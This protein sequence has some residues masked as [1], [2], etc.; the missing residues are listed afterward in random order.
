MKNRL[1]EYLRK[2]AL[3]PLI[4]PTVL[5]VMF[6]CSFGGLLIKTTDMTEG[7]YEVLIT[8]VTSGVSGKNTCYGSIEDIGKVRVICDEQLNPGDRLIVYAS[9]FEAPKPSNPGEYDYQDYLFRKGIRY[10]LMVQDIRERSES[11]A[12][13]KIHHFRYFVR[14]LIADKLRNDMSEDDLAI[15]CALCLGDTS[16]IGDDIRR[17]F[18]LSGCSHLLAVSG[19]HFSSFILIISYAVKDMPYRRK[20]LIQALFVIVIGFLTGWTESVTRAAVMSM[21]LLSGKDRLSG[22]S[23]SAL[24]MML[25]D[26]FCC[27]TLSFQMSFGAGLGMY[28]VSEPIKGKTGSSVISCSLASRAVMLPYFLMNG[29]PLGFGSF[30]VMALSVLTVQMVCLFFLPGFLLSFISPYM[31]YPTIL[32]SRITIIL[33][34]IGED[35]YFDS[36][37]LRGSKLTCILLVFC[38][39][40]VYICRKRKLVVSVLSGTMIV[41]LLTMTPIFDFDK[42]VLFLD[43]GQGDSCL[44]IS[45]N[46]TLLI[47]GG[48]Y[49]EG[50]SVLPSVLDYYQIQSIDLAIATHLDEDH[51]GGIRYLE[52][53]GRVDKIVTSYSDIYETIKEGDVIKAGKV[54]FQ[55]LWPGGRTYNGGNP[56]SVVGVLKIDG[57]KIMMTGDIDEDSERIMVNRGLISDCDI[58]KVA[59]HGSKTSSSLEFLSSVSPEAAVVS[60]A[61]YN[62]YGHP[63]PETLERLG[64]VEANV[65]LTSKNGAIIVKIQKDKYKINCF[66][67]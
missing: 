9:L 47:D 35:Y 7:E 11:K 8:G 37:L 36:L 43:V 66:K 13:T 50:K 15:V 38:L 16:M 45:G 53:Q 23:F 21:C 41:I 58:L 30:A 49:E 44:I 34:D 51:L 61:E 27:R 18:D 42:K 24:L 22:M 26:P 29:I 3:R 46:D 48:T 31:L 5:L 12:G 55:V 56:E 33:M 67:E 4:V 54:E 63:A 65:F 32:F 1:R 64:K 14:D 2:L 52:E 59:H 6:M 20:V 39:T 19:T 60:V 40:A 17:S 25:S 57:V 28:L 62:V 10:I